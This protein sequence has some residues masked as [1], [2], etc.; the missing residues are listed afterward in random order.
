[1]LRR[2]TVIVAMAA[3]FASPGGALAEANVVRV[4]KQFGVGYM[5]Y[6][7]MQ[8]L[9]LIEKHAKAS[10]LDITTEWATFR[11]SDVMNDALISGSV[12][13]VSLGVPGIITVHSKTKGTASEVKGVMGLN[14]SPLWLM[15]RDPNIKSLKDFTDNH[16]IALPAVKVSNQA[17]IL[18]MAAAKEFGDAKYAALDHLTVSMSHPDATA[19]MLGG[20]SEI[21][22][23]FSS[24]PFQYRQMKN[25]N[26]KRLINSKDLFTDDPMSFNVVA[27][28]S[29]F[30]NDNPKLY[31]AFVAGMKEATDFI[32]AD[33]RKGAEIYLKVSGEKASVDD[34]M[35][36]LADPDI[37]YNNRVGGIRT[38]V[39]F[40]T[41][42][43]TLKNPPKDW[44]DMFFPE[45]MAGS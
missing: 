30:R 25:P 9:K 15:V 23:N 12:D 7:V 16:R 44:K 3:W 31:A 13:F 26:V 4:A 37:V 10:G 28:T 19:A 39:E 43:G 33:K 14:V 20:Q 38:F 22:A 41:K 21:T 32:N 45:A 1:M 27:A 6:M 40:M 11:S 34:I 36:V 5:Q 8:E 29:K 42:T 24:A 2:L 35:D 17:I 18:Q